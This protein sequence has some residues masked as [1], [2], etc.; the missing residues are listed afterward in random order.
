MKVHVFYFNPYY[1]CTYVVSEND[2]AIVID[3]GVS[4][5]AEATAF[6]QYIEANHLHLMDCLVTHTHPDHICGNEFLEE[7]FGVKPHEIDNLSQIEIFNQT[8]QI[9]ATPGHKSDSVCFYFPK[10]KVL[11]TG[12]TLFM[13]SVGRTDL[14]TGD[15]NTLLQSLQKLMELPNDT[16]VYPGHGPKTTI[17]HE[18]QFNPFIA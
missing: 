15:W 6:K 10:E 11:F 9:L 14:P 16:V 7:E 8:M 12:D 2:E 5:P 3:C 17:G 4:N 18:K 1:E 13:E